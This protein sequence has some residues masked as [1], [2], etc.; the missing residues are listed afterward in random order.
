[1]EKENLKTDSFFQ[2]QARF[3]FAVRLR[4]GQ[5]G[6]TPPTKPATGRISSSIHQLVGPSSLSAEAWPST[7]NI[8]V[9]GCWLRTTAAS[10]CNANRTLEIQARQPTIINL[11]PTL[12]LPNRHHGGQILVLSHN[13]LAKV[14]QP[15]PGCSVNGDANS[16]T[17]ASWFRSVGRPFLRF[18]ACDSFQLAS[19]MPSLTTTQSM[20]L[21]P[22]TKA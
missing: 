19:R 13:I 17:A 21:T 14:S 10:T 16:P 4:A 9:P 6:G 1:M 7:R 2:F 15:P 3:P 18:E 5:P 20:R 11:Q 8:A 12:S 22:S